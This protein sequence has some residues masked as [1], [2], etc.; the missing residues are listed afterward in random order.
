VA[1]FS[2]AGLSALPAQSGPAKTTVEFPGASLKWVH[3]AE[4]EFQRR[5]LN[6]DNHK[7]VIDEEGDSVAICLLSNDDIPGAKGSSGSHPD[8]TVEI[9]RYDHKIIRSYYEK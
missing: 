5:H 4:P 2:F 3:L 8:F 6:L 9:N 7:V 1:A